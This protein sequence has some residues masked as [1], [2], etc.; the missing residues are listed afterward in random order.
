MSGDR[1]FLL[2][3]GFEDPDQPGRFFVC[4]HCNAIEGLLA[5]FP[6]LATQIEVHRL[7]F[8]RP[9]TALVEILGEQHQSLPVLVFDETQPVP[10]DAGVA[11]GRRFLDSSER[12][13]R[14]LAD[15]YAFPYVHHE[16]IDRHDVDPT[17]PGAAT[18]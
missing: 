7:P 6:G 15:R 2:K 12:I 13:L 3:P 4:P 9:R 14:Y 11:N 17:L 10:E 1:L 5:S 16:G 18:H 8:L